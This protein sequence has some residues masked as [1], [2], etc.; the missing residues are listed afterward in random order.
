MDRSIWPKD[1][2]L[3]G[4]TPPDQRGSERNGNEGILQIPQTP[5]L[6]PPVVYSD[7]DS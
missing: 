4:T 3:T 6:E 1:G 5:G 2:T 7:A